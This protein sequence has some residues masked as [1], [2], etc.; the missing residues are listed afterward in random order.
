MHVFRLYIRTLALLGSEKTLAILLVFANI[1]LAAAS[2]A[3]PVLFGWIIDLLTG[4]QKDG[5][6]ITW[7]ALTPLT[8]AWVSFGLF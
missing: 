2:F 5:K 1:F 3:E 6:T 4:A 7:A 8:I